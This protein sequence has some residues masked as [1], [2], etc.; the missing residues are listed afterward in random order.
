MNACTNVLEDGGGQYAANVDE[1]INPE[2][3]ELELDRNRA[4]T[5]EY[6]IQDFVTRLEVQKCSQRKRKSQQLTVMLLC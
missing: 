5:A 3:E 4:Q 1:D 6:L 2:D